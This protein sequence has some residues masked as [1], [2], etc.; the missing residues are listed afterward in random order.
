M[1]LC[2]CSYEFGLLDLDSDT[3]SDSGSD[4]ASDSG[5]DTAS[6]TTQAGGG[7]ATLL[8]STATYYQQSGAQGNNGP[9]VYLQNPKALFQNPGKICWSDVDVDGATTYDVHYGNPE[10]GTEYFHLTF[11]NTVQSTVGLTTAGGWDLYLGR[12]TGSANGSGKQTVCLEATSEGEGI[13]MA[14]IERVVIGH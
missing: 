9:D 10:P 14:A 5:S 11:G 12:A 6:D 4:T 8:A 13:W 1:G 7:S 2:S 3:A